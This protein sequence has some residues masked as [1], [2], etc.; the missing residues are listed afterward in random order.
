VDRFVIVVL[1]FLCCLLAVRSAWAVEGEPTVLVLWGS[2]LEW[3]EASRV[4]EAELQ[5]TGFSVVR[6]STT[7]ASPGQLIDELRKATAGTN[8][9]GAVTVFRGQPT[10]RAFVWLPEKEDLVQ[11]ES[12]FDAENVA[13]EVLAL[14]IVEL[15]RTRWAATPEPTPSQ[16]VVA[17]PPP[18]RS[19][20]WLALGPEFSFASGQ[21]P[22]QFAAGGNVLLFHHLLFELS[23]ATSLMADAPRSTVGTVEVRKTRLSLH[24][25]LRV[26]PTD[27]IEGALGPGLGVVLLGARGRAQDDTLTGV[28]SSP[29]LLQAS[30]RA[31][32]SWRSGPLAALVL[33]EFSWLLPP[34]S[35]RAGD[36]E[37]M[38]YS[39][40]AVFIGGGLAWAH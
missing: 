23:G 5:A 11:L 14:R 33:A 20:V 2:E 4:L 36:N 18:V 29:V 21:G 39:G 38:S 25:L 27:S 3:D 30:V 7:A 26:S 17:E 16:R 31:R 32:G 9:R 10:P 34:L 19:I 28:E 37:V 35:F 1:G 40:A 15:L 13:P 24:S 6:R 8:L 22:F 12:P